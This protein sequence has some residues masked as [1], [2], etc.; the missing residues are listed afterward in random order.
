M[1]RAAFAGPADKRGKTL[2]YPENASKIA[3]F[4]APGQ[5]ID[6]LKNHEHLFCEAR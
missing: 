3:A 1:A 6:G 5:R 2:K 4:S